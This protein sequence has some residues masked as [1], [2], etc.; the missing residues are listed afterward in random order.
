MGAA[1]VKACVKP[2]RLPHENMCSEHEEVF[3]SRAVFPAYLTQPVQYFEEFW[4]VRQCEG[5]PF[6]KDVPNLRCGKIRM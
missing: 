3:I 1:G 2:A 5:L 4:Y 6:E